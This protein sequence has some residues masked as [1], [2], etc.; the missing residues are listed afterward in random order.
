MKYQINL[1]TYPW[2]ASTKPNP[3]HINKLR[4]RIDEL[5]RDF[6]V[7]RTNDSHEIS[8]PITAPAENRE[9]EKLLRTFTQEVMALQKDKSKG[10]AGNITAKLEPS[11]MKRARFLQLLWLADDVNTYEDKDENTIDLNPWRILCKTCGSPDLSRPPNPFILNDKIVSKKKN[12]NL[13]GTTCGLLIVRRPIRDLLSSALGEQFESGDTKLAKGA[14]PK[15]ENQL[16]W[17][18]PKQSFPHLSSQFVHESCK[19][20]GR[21]VR[22]HKGDPNEEDPKDDD[23]PKVMFSDDREKVAAY[24]DGLDLAPSEFFFGRLRPGSTAGIH[25]PI[26]IS[27]SLYDHLKRN[28]LKGTIVYDNE[29]IF[30]IKDESPVEQS[31]RTFAAGASSA[32]PKTLEYDPK[33]SKLPWDHM[34]DGYIYFHLS[35]PDLYVTDP[36]L[37]DDSMSATYTLKKFKPGVHRLPVSA[38]KDAGRRKGV[39]VDSA[40]LLF[41]DAALLADLAENFNWSDSMTS[42]HGYSPAYLNKI[43]KQIGT[44]FGLCTAPGTRSKHDFKGDGEY[45]IDV[46]A[47]E[48]V[49]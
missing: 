13:F 35:S 42:R 32:K 11:E 16:F 41:V 7:K 6:D 43:A 40:T 23:Q 2:Q 28:G 14:S 27:G 25:F 24:P 26:I 22:I 20:C 33:L 17:I 45:I 12:F 38:I 15:G 39:S 44:R 19:A 5:F 31:S 4:K 30:S 47:I 37:F 48:R 18:R 21:P 46:K 3:P 29:A 36:M 34:K 10:L 49:G 1:Q 9:T 8:A